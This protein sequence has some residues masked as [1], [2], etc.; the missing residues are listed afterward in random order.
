MH[1]VTA[2]IKI[3]MNINLI[4]CV[5]RWYIQFR[6]ALRNFLFGKQC[7]QQISVKVNRK[8]VHIFFTIG[9]CLPNLRGLYRIGLVLV[10]KI[11]SVKS[12]IG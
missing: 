7:C 4:F 9:E 11:L 2:K 1:V 12:E 8:M 6:G 5:G 3:M 10:K